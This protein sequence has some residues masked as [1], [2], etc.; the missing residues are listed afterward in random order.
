MSSKSLRSEYIDSIE[1][2]EFTTDDL[3][4]ILVYG[5][6]VGLLIVIIFLMYLFILDVK[7]GKYTTNKHVK[8]CLNLCRRY[9]ADT[10]LPI[11][12]ISLKKA[13]ES[14]FIGPYKSTTSPILPN[15]DDLTTTYR[16]RT[17]FNQEIS[18]Y[19]PDTRITITVEN[20]PR[21]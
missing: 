17:S 21:P 9:K 18:F 19:E 11:D 2:Y 12:K 16:F 15:L 3:K 6:I 5:I 14:P 8:T 4:S 13:K 1:H 20:T 7:D 10:L